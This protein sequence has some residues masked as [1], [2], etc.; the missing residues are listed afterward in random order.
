MAEKI[1]IFS[2]K[3]YSGKDTAAKIMLEKMPDFKRC[4]MG[5]IIKITYGKEKKLS[6]EEIEKNKAVYRQDLINL[7]NWGRSQDPDYWL[8]KILEQDGNIIVTDVRVPHEYEVFKNAGALT[9]RVEATRETRAKRGELIGETDITET[10][11]DNIKN[12]D[13][14]IDNNGDYDNLTKQ[15]IEI[16][17]KINN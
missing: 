12:W 9:I 14:I 6:Y 10:G 2:G 3:Q 11:L 8:K 16:I 15:V 4:A 7:G 1:I 13:F 5:D 17:N